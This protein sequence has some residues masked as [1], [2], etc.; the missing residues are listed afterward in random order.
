VSASTIDALIADV[1]EEARRQVRLAATQVRLA[2]IEGRSMVAELQRNT[3]IALGGDETAV[4]PLPA[5]LAFALRH[6]RG[7]TV[8]RAWCSELWATSSHH[9]FVLADAL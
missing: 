5:D 2:E 6:H 9:A 4:A 3:V 7:T 8:F 1:D